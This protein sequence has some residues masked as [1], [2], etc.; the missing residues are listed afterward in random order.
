MC[1]IWARLGEKPE[2]ESVEY[3]VNKLVARGPEGTQIREGDG[4]SLGFTRLAINGLNEEG[5]QPMSFGSTTYVCNGEIYNWKD[6]ANRYAVENTSGS[7][8]EVL[9]ELW[10]EFAKHNT[11]ATFFQSLDGVFAIVL[12]DEATKTAYVARDPYG[13]RPLFV[14]YTMGNPMN[15]PVGGRS[16]IQDGSGKYVPILN[17]Y[18][19]SEM[20]ALQMCDHIEVFPP[21]HCAAYDIAS[22]ARVGFEPYHSIPWIKNPCYAD[23]AKAC[24]AIRV[25][26]IDAVKKRMLM[27][28]PVAAL[29][30]G[31]LDSSLIAALVQKELGEAQGGRLKTFSIGFEGSE[32]LKC[33]KLVAEHIGSDH[34]EVVMTADEFWDAI[35]NVIADI[36]SY[37][38]TTVRASVGNWLVSKYIRENTNC[39]VVFNGDGSDEVFGGYLYFYNAPSDEAFEAESARLLKDIHLFDVLRSDRSISSHGLEARTPFLDKQFV[40]C[41]RSVSTA[42]RRPVLGEKCEKWIVRKA[43]EGTGLLPDAILWRKKEAF[44]DGVSGGE[45]S[46]YEICKEKAEGSVIGWEE[47]AKGITH[48]QP[49]SAEAYYYRWLFN[50]KYGYKFTTAMVPYF[51]M[52]KWCKETSDPSARTLEIYSSDALSSSS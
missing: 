12:I 27:D 3:H 31:G 48:L 23:E 39:K 41:A 24:E 14:G 33:A 21:G 17:I 9:G 34:T 22:L 42:L 52:P 11:G 32:D 2:K 4:W 29:L 40:S 25:S 10:E 19:A 46:W 13:V 20:K 47:R 44:S 8:C 45:K 49:K 16:Y 1:G 5:M 50:K 6:L 18:F 38:I 30:S 26:L 28:R 36:E 35:P 51:W 7:D 43:F 37:D 15:E